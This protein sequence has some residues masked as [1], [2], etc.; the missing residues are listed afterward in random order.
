MVN[1]GSLPDEIL[2]YIFSKLHPYQDLESCKQVNKRWNYI[3]E[4]DCIFL[5]S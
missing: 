1:V 4:G 2:E 3:A 5:L